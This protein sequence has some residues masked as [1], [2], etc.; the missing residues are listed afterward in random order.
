VNALT[1]VLLGQ[2]TP[3]APEE[4]VWPIAGTLARPDGT[5]LRIS[6]ARV[7]RRWD[8]RSGRF[9]EE[10]S[11]ESRASAGAVVE[12]KAFQARL[13]KGPSG[14]Y[15]VVVREEDREAIAERLPLGPPG[16]LPAG[17]ASAP[18][19]LAAS[20]DRLQEFLK[21]AKKVARGELPATAEQEKAW[22]RGL[23]NEERLLAELALK[24]DFTATAA[25][26]GRVGMLLRN[27]QIW[28]GRPADD[29][30]AAFLEDDVSFESLDKM[31]V[32]TPAVLAAEL[33]ASTTTL[34]ALLAARAVDKPRLLPALHDAARKAVAALQGATPEFLEAAEAAAQAGVED[35]PE[36]RKRLEALRDALIEAPSK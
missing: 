35:L 8:A 26:L 7:E 10:L 9:R 32:A 25:H 27:A 14:L 11:S 34:L 6:A 5:E 18:D 15:Q 23:G 28:N 31:L 4:R 17:W 16:E 29:G 36:L 13:R 33:K 22:S 24:S 19:K 1:L 21:T 20:R 30:N 3:G 2:L 12:R